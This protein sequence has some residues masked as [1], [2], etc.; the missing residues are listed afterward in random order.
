MFTSTRKVIAV[1]VAATVAAGSY[2]GATQY[3]HA[4]TKVTPP[5]INLDNGTLARLD[6]LSHAMR[7]VGK[8]M[9]QSVVKI[10]VVKSAEAAGNGGRPQ[11]KMDLDGDGVP[12]ELPFN[13]GPDQQGPVMGE[14]SGVIMEVRGDTGYILTN[15]HVAGG[16][17]E[18]VIELADGRRIE[19]AKVLGT[20]PKADLAVIEVKAPDL[21][22]ARWGDSDKVERGDIVM[23]FGSPFGYVGSMSQGIVSGKDRDTRLLGQLGYENFIQTDAV[24]NPGNSGGPLVDVRGNVIGI[25][26]AIATR[27]GVYN[28]I[29]FAIPVNQA[30]FVY[31][32][33]RDTG[34]VVR[35]YLGV[36][37]RDV[38]VLNARQLD[39]L[40]YEDRRNG[41]F[42]GKVSNDAPAAGALKPGDVITAVD[43]V[44]VRTTQALR[45]KIATIKPGT[46]V[47]LDVW[48]NKKRETVTVKL[49]EQP[50]EVVVAGNRR[51]EAPTPGLAT[52]IGVRL[53]D[54]TPAQL[55]QLGLGEDAKGA[56]VT[57]IRNNSI[58]AMAGLEPG[59]LITRIGD[60]DVESAEQAQKLLKEADLSAGVNL[61][62]K[63][64]DG[65]ASVFVQKQ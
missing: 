49:G 56:L 13:F 14:G 5:S 11:F 28:G 21:V 24:I 39:S 2:F 1:A 8:L 42:V 35:G 12:D 44:D 37:I 23:A 63:S 30:K 3:L 48:R 34:K 60:A 26:V 57:N 62:V 54:P 50:A 19:N 40:G 47:K 27:T 10:D 46:E 15:N 41:V 59:A 18:M 32:Q 6:D 25:N 4:E 38:A 61:T 64:R 7:E 33:L 43:G 17:S 9:E 22:P 52:D 36:E 53:A 31:E 58:A 16:A 55:K 29:G 51:G 20:D 45:L 65:E